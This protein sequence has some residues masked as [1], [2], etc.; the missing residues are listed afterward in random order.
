MT[1]ADKALADLSDDARAAVAA[2]DAAVQKLPPTSELNMS[3]MPEGAAG[4]G[5]GEERL[6]TN[7]GSKVRATCISGCTAETWCSGQAPRCARW[8]LG[9]TSPVIPLSA[10]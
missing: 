1:L 8:V 7:P 2:V 10:P 6:P 4:G 5:F 3:V 9:A